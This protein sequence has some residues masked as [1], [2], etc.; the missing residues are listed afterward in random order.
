MPDQAPPRTITRWL[1]AVTPITLGLPFLLL[2]AFGDFMSALVLGAVH[3]VYSLVVAVL[4]FR[5]ARRAGGW[6]RTRDIVL[7]VL[8]IL[9]GFAGVGGGLLLVSMVGGGMALGGA[10]GRPLRVRGRQLHPE[11]RVGADWTSGGRPDA[12]GLD[13]ATRR[14]LEALWLHDAQKEHA[15]VPA[16][17]RVSWMLAATGAPAALLVGAHR[18]AMEEIDHAQ[19]CFALAAGYGGRAHT[20]E[21]MPDLL[22]GGLDVTGDARVVLAEESLRDGCLLED[23]NADVAAACEAA[24]QEPVTRDVLGRIAREERDHAEFSWDV[25]AWALD[26][27]G[28]RVAAA[29]ER[30][31]ARLDEVVRPTAA[32]SAVAPLVAAADP[33]ALR[34]HGR[35]TD[36]EWGACWDARLVATR[37][38]AR[39][40][41]DG[42][43]ALAA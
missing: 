1:A 17:S 28:P 24:C 31:L 2:F 6:V 7:G 35:L 3:I 10:W 36:A 19:R 32:S 12:A 43:E 29:V 8:M 9:V 5:D 34:A 26:V 14:A 21:P 16:F 40:L 11:L 20:V 15:S 25:L 4:F 27:G 38:R 42:V 33:G 41:L 39:A 18:A 37:A 30:A 22:L 13:A 23:F